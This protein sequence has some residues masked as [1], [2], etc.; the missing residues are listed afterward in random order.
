MASLVADRIER[1]STLFDF[2]EGP[3]ATPAP[4]RPASGGAAHAHD[5]VG[6]EP[7]LDDMVVGVW[8]GLTAQAAVACPL[9]EGTLRPLYAGGG[10][11]DPVVAGRCD[12]CGTTLS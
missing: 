4:V 3:P 10:G 11:S 6:G 1:P 9:C 12:R 8:E 2:V 5:G 7:T